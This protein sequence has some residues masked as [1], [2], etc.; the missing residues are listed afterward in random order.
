MSTED[1]LRAKIQAYEHRETQWKAQL[2]KAQQE[3]NQ[4]LTYQQKLTQA[5]L[6]LKSL[7]QDNARLQQEL[8]QSTTTF[9]T[10]QNNFQ[11][12][13]E[14]LE[15]E[16]K[17]QNSTSQSIITL[18]LQYLSTP[19]KGEEKEDVTVPLQDS[20]SLEQV[21]QYVDTIKTK[22][23]N[24][25]NEKDT[26]ITSLKSQIKELQENLENAKQNTNV[27]LNPETSTIPSDHCSIHSI[28]QSIKGL[29]DDT[30]NFAVDTSL[31]LPLLTLLE[32]LR[33]HLQTIV[34]TQ[35]ANQL[36]ITDETKDLKRQ[37]TQL[38]MN[39]NELSDEK[40]QWLMEKD[41]LKAKLELNDDVDELRQKLKEK[42]NDHKELQSRLEQLNVEKLKLSE[43]ITTQHKE[44]DTL[45]SNCQ[46]YKDEFNEINNEK[47]S[48]LDQLETVENEMTNLKE[49]HQKEKD[50]LHSQLNERQQ[51]NQQQQSLLDSIE[52]LE[53]K[54]NTIELE[55]KQQEE[56]M[57]QIKQQEH[58]PLI[59]SIKSLEEKLDA[60]EK[61]RQQYQDQVEKL[62]REHQGLLDKISNIKE[63]IT[64]RLES[65]KQLRVKVTE[66]S[67]ELEQAKQSVDE[68]RAAM[69]ARDQE[70]NQQLENKERHLYQLQMRFEKLQREKE[71]LEMSAMQLD[72]RCSQVEEKY[73]I[74]LADLNE[75]KKQMADEM[76]SSASERA[77]LANLQTVLEEFQATKDA[78]IRAAVEHIE[79]QL[80]VAKKSWA[81]YQER[82]RVAESALEQYQQD[83]AKTQ[84]YEREIKEKNLLIGKLRHEA[85]ILNEHLVEAMRR[86]KEETNESNVDRQLI[87]NLL[88][89]FFLAP[90]GDR[91]RFDILTIISNVLQMTDEQ[92]EQVGLIRM[93]QNG[94]KS[95]VG[96]QGQQQTPE[97]KESF[98]D[99]W[100]SFLLKESSNRKPNNQ[101]SPQQDQHDI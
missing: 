94:Q 27:V 67:A 24:R 5:G 80:E 64:P 47:K 63:T 87:T 97:P 71:E 13:K 70:S 35:Q 41:E 72:A 61:E 93:K 55:K 69:V 53:Q 36:H 84:Q 32:N 26:T 46:T 38:Q 37:I 73:A 23:K 92:K 6:H 14:V 12:E 18:L 52:Q 75:Y 44:I 58:Q 82:A 49:T 2:E 85:I 40:Q 22:K 10:T 33:T 19:E 60:T 79:R 8:K 76:E 86:L 4:L 59:E 1:A 30:D 96:W 83:V 99:A 45:E 42:E 65:E 57:E 3:R 66:L 91:K 74:S 81:E 90:R 21:K 95:P 25:N 28:E 20:S 15:T 62:Q 100:I 11:K 51:N 88:V 77:S 43:K 7:A 16:L 48:L 39:I 50:Q 98:T 89:G 56:K 78:E 54:I 9:E 31:P 34:V 68:M 29:I 17:N 101:N